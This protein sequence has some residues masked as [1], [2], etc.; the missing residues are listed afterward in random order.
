[1]SGRYTLRQAAEQLGIHKITLYRWEKEG[2]IQAPKR[3]MRNKERIFSDEDIARIRDW[4]DK[5]ID[6]SQSAAP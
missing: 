6:P 2:K 3:L 4:K 5:I 1:M